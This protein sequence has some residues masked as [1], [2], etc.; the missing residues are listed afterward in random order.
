[1]R[2]N[3]PVVGKH[4]TFQ[5]SLAGIASLAI[6]AEVWYIIGARHFGVWLS[7]VE[8]CVRDAEVARSNR[9]IPTTKWR[10]I[11]RGRQPF[12][13]FAAWLRT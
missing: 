5:F 11:F 10:P 6:F 7:P 8:R 13:L 12:C 1:M 4:L 3:P 9:A 2:F